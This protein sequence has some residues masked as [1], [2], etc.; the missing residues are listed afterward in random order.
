M[1]NTTTTV[2]IASTA[3]LLA[4]LFVTRSPAEPPP[5]GRMY[6]GPD[7]RTW[8]DHPLM[9][10]ETCCL[11]DG[12]CIELYK[13]TCD[14]FG[15]IYLGNVPC[16]SRNCVRVLPPTGSQD[17][18][19]VFFSPNGGGTE[20]II[21]EIDN[22]QDAVVVQAYSFTSAPIAKALLNA[23]DRA[24]A[25]VVVLDSSQL[26]AKYNSATFFHNQEMA[27]YI[28]ADHAIAPNNV[29]VIDR[30]TIITG[31]FD[32]SKAAE[33]RNAENVLIITGK[34]DLA[35]AYLDNIARHF[36]H[37]EPYVGPADPPDEERPPGTS[38]SPR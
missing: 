35:R 36:A 37:S 9:P 28:D 26:T 21:N 20:A 5:R 32:F 33:E 22:A 4:A 18:I 25:V 31:S 3:V 15:G 34:P 10:G 27:V 13:S 8:Y 11:P 16:D 7:G 12:T 2:V 38:R 23:R 6:T 29:M 14:V 19:E 30:E 1:R 24:V 17:G